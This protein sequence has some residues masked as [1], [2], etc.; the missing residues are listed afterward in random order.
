MQKAYSAAEAASVAVEMAEEESRKGNSQD[1]TAAGAAAT[2]ESAKV[3]GSPS[4]HY[5]FQAWV[6]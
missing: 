2:L 1:A 6:T 4:C 3:Q 5:P